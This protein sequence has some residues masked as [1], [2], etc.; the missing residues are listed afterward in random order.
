MSVSKNIGKSGEQIA[1]EYLKSRGYEILAS[2]WQLFHR[3]LDIIAKW[4][5]T[6][7]FI[8]VKTRKKS[9]L[10]NPL[11]TVTLK[12]QRN[13]IEAANLFM[14]QK[15][16]D[17]ESRFDIITIVYSEISIEIE[18]LEN[19]FYPSVKKLG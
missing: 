13:I 9:S 16:I 15:K 4:N 2:N 12:K 11:N 6:L 5:N 17:M 19:A 3:E 8:E 18:H 1:I 7:I 10:V 14:N